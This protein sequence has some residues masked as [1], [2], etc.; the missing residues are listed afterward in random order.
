MLP[1]KV[2]L[3]LKCGVGDIFVIVVLYDLCLC[4]IIFDV[5]S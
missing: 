2:S 3:R 1:A 5:M 4:I